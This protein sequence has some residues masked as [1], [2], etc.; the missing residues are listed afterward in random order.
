MEFNTKF[1]KALTCALVLSACCGAAVA[2]TPAAAPAAPSAAAPMAHPAWTRDA[3]IYEVNIRQYTKE[4]TFKAFAAHLPRLKKMGVDI[5]W[6]M[7]VQPIGEKNRKGTLGSY[8]AVRDYTAVNPEFGNMADFKSLVD[9][10]HRLGM[11]VILDWVANHTAWDNPWVTEHDNWYKKDAKGQIFPVTFTNGAEPEYW[12]DVVA[13]DYTQP[14]LWK[15][16]TEAMAFWV[17]EANVDGFRCDV[18][19]LVPTPFWNQARAELDKI[20]PVFMLAE[21]DEPGLHEQAFD[22]TYDWNLSELFKKIGKGQ[23]DARDLVAYVAKPAKAYPGH[24]YRMLFTNNHDLNSWQGTDKELYGP[25]YK[26][27]AVLAATLPGMPLVYGGQEAGLDKRLAFFEKDPIV[28]NDYPNEKF[29]TDL[30]KL[31]K[32]NPALRNGQYGA[33]AQTLATGNDKVFAFRRAQA[34]NAV[35]VVVNVSPGKQGFRLPGAKGQTIEPWAWR[36]VTGK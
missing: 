13:L 7:P 32:V 5:L 31:K 33:P 36:I 8:Y 15:G 10:A 16:M 6:L 3:N 35:T 2:Q 9:E 28:W 29:Y 30:L 22:M 1:A 12:T 17:R 26:A 25:A 24:A 4:G 21:W 14:A 20:K 18:A 19:G 11:R 23:A 27:L 34:G